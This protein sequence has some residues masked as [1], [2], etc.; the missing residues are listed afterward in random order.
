MN[1]SDDTQ[2]ERMILSGV[3]SKLQTAFNL[4]NEPVLISSNDKWNTADRLKSQT[5]GNTESNK[6]VLQLPLCTLRLSQLSVNPMAYNIQSLAKYGTYSALAEG[7]TVYTRYQFIPATYQFELAYQCQDFFQMLAFS[8]NCV[9]FSYQKKTLSF[10]LN[11]DGTPIDVRVQL[12]DTIT[13]PDKDAVVDVVNMYDLVTMLTVYSY[14]AVPEV[15]TVSALQNLNHTVT[16][17][18]GGV[19]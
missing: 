10:S 2:I 17:L 14:I 1:T 7:S 16:A 19:V 13:M 9:A 15:N 8:R 3:T 5:V 4:K 18:A 6:G 12:D 11:Y